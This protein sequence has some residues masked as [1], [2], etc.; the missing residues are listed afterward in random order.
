MLAKVDFKRCF[1]LG[2]ALITV[3]VVGGWNSPGAEAQTVYSPAQAAAGQAAASGARRRPAAARRSSRR[4]RS[5]G[6]TLL[7]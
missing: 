4:A 5:P 1:L 2:V 6:S 3:L 7:P